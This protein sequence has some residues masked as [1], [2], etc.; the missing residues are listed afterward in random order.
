MVERRIARRPARASGGKLPNG[1]R[2][3][4]FPAPAADDVARV[5]IKRKTNLREIFQGECEGNAVIVHTSVVLHDKAER[6]DPAREVA[7]QLVALLLED[8]FVEL[9]NFT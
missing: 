1:G 9:V 5:E 3:V 4:T 8:T 6:R 7:M 2:L